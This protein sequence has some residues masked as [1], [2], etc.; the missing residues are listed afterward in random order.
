[1]D[2]FIVCMSFASLNDVAHVSFFDDYAVF[3]GWKTRLVSI[4][5]TARQIHR[6]ALPT[7]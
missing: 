1:M 3:S 4:F 7:S 6:C 2:L 5:H